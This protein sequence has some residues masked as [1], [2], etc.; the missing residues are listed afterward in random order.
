MAEASS[1]CCEEDTEEE[2]VA[3]DECGDCEYLEVAPDEEETS[4]DLDCSFDLVLLVLEL[5]VVL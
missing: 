1:G 2:E 4:L 5:F 3:D